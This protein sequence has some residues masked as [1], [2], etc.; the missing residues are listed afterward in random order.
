MTSTYAKLIKNKEF[1]KHFE[2]EYQNLV[3][4]EMICALMENDH[5]SVRKLA[6]DSGLAPSFIQNLRSGKQK[7][8]KLSNLLSLSE[9]LGYELILKNK[10]NKKEIPLRELSMGMFNEL[11]HFYYLPNFNLSGK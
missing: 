1:A 8:L 6:K 11:C 4:S 7:D 2:I 9:N 5:V 3:L 10:E